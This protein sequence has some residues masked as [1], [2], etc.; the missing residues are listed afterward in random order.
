MGSKI[1]KSWNFEILMFEIMKWGFY[2]T[3]LE[4]I[5]SRKLSNLLFK[6]NSPNNRQK[7]NNCP[8]SC[9]YDFPQ[10]KSARGPQTM[11]FSD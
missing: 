8:N 10:M 7:C 2:C 4:Q 5:T 3:N 6:H 9:S 11:I 1:E